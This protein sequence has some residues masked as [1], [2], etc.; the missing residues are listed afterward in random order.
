MISALVLIGVLVALALLPPIQTWAARKALGGQP[1]TRTELARVAA[2]TSSAAIDGVLWEKDGLVVRAARVVA[3]YSAWDFVTHRRVT[4]HDLTVEGLEID[5]RGMTAAPASAAAA[6]AQPAP[7]PNSPVPAP[8]SRAAGDRDAFRG[9]LN[10]LELP[11][12]LQIARFAVPGRVLLPDG[13]TAQ[14]DVRGSDISNGKRGTIDWTVDLANTTPGAALNAAQLS[15]TAHLHLTT[16]RRIDLIELNALGTAKGPKLPTDRIKFEAKAEQPTLGGDE[17]YAANISLLQ[18][19]TT[20]PLVT[21]AGQYAAS[22]HELSGAWKVSVRTEQLS[23]LLTGLGLPEI[24]AEGSGKFSARPDAGTAAADGE[25]RSEISQLERVS[26]QLAPARQ[27]RVQAAFAAG[28]ADR[29]L[30]LDRLNLAATAAD[31]RKLADVRLLQPI[32]CALDDFTFAPEKPDA[33]A[34]RLELGQLPLTW[35][36]TLLPGGKL[37]GEVSA[38]VFAMTLRP[39]MDVAV[40]TAEPV[41]L[42]AISVTLNQQPM[43]RDVDLAADLSLHL[44]GRKIQ[45]EIR[46]FEARSRTASLL[47]ITSQGEA[48]L[49]PKL[50]VSAKGAVHAD[51]AALTQ[52]PLGASAMTL[53]RGNLEVAFDATVANTVRADVSATVRNLLAQ[54][55]GPPLGDADLKLTATVQPDGSSVLRMPFTLT[56]GQRKSDLLVDGKLTRTADRVAFDG[57]VTSERLVLDDLQTLAALA[58]K[59]SATPVAAPVPAPTRPATGNPVGTPVP[60]RD[61]TPFWNAFGGRIEVDLKQ[62]AYGRDYTISGV[63]GTLAAS[64]GELALTGFEGKLKEN[65]F[66]MAATVT[67]NA[68]QPKPYALT[69]SANVT[70][71]NLGEFLRAAAPDEKPQIETSVT[72]EAKLNGQGATISDLAQNANGVF[73]LSGSKGVLRALARKGGDAV[74]LGSTLLGVLGAVKSSE[75]T[76]AVAELTKKLA[77]LPFDRFSMRIERGTD[78]N[79]KISQ[80]EFLSP[81]T[82]ITGN[83]AITYQA[84]TPIQ[85]QPLQVTLALAGKD[86]MAYLLNRAGLLG[87]QPDAQGFYPLSRQFAVKGT[88]AKPDAK[89]L[90]TLILQAMAGGLLNR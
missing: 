56:N 2:G 88:P 77:E 62:I 63:H 44:V 1:G 34:L 57:R 64:P 37:G 42:H 74:N 12:D 36:E 58:P 60:T 87:G 30:R 32:A 47:T 17:G 55:G 21:L 46:R 3:K 83:G 82:R 43:L 22:T 14:F 90:W 5:A 70:Q 48:Q 89:E 20:T 78:L 71:F 35:A 50:A 52:Q 25:F 13:M 66:R 26:A 51:L 28:I 80:L 19:A 27:L 81:D 16:E 6:S 8:A 79:L 4:V 24:A 33:E 76:V 18:G 68:Q 69:G 65:P 23:A 59:T 85:N 39:G 7:R 53:N 61:A 72:I 73:D 41:Q 31:G 86:N 29:R 75:G 67:F 40:T 15:G 49:S 38:G 9:V 45:Y 84:G 54:Q 11:V 10:Q